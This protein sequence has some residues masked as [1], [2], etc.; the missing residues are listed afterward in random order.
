MNEEDIFEI[1]RRWQ[2]GQPIAH[3]ARVEDWD[4]KTIRGYIKKIEHAG[5]ASGS[6]LVDQEEV[7]K[8]LA[9]M[10]PQSG[11]PNHVYQQLVGLA[12]AF[13]GLINHPDEPVRP[14]TAFE[15][16][17]EQKGLCC[18]YSTFKRFARDF[19][20]SRKEKKDIIRIELPAGQQTQLDY[21]KMGLLED[22]K[23]GGRKIVYAFIGVLSHC[24]LPFVQFV[25]RQDQQSFVGS[26]MDMFDF[27]GGATA[28]ICIDNL[29]AGVIKPDMYEPKLNPAFR[30]M[31]EYYGVFIDPCR[32]GRAT[33]KGKVERMVQWVRELFRKLRHLYPDAGI[34]ELNKQAR[35]RCLEEYGMKVHGTTG[36]KPLVVFETVEKA[37]LK[38]LPE[39]RFEIPCWQKAKVHPD[40]FIQFE[41]KRYSVPGC[42][43]G[44]EL[45]VR[46]SG[47]MIKIYYKYQLV[48]EYVIP[49]GHMAYDPADF[50]LVVREMLDG[51]YPKYLLEQARAYGKEAYELIEYILTPHAYINARRAQGTL[52][53]MAG[54]CGRGYFALVCERARRRSVKL[55]RVL[56][57]M[58]EE[59]EACHH[60]APL[61]VSEVGRAMVRSLDYYLSKEVRR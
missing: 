55:P 14:K 3:I 21:A 44:M 53:V 12:A 56:R 48:K 13:R 33:D 46:K 27:Y 28:V 10:V 29:K 23:T 35:K 37:V 22:K 1:L 32:V 24:R 11:R 34:E 60:H 5:L 59:A 51:G 15:I 20:L 49:R 50:P 19:G 26:V 47:N 17:Q 6:L 43:R 25:F 39:V 40:R 38:K 2:A 16:I 57:R 9:Q 31:A 58:M 18:S 42:Y 30:G 41:K 45:W 61:A 4:R 54:Y 52:R 7:Y 8:F 36:L